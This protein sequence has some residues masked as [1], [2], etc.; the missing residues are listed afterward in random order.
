MLARHSQRPTARHWNGVKHVLQYLRRIE[1][2]GLH[3]TKGGTP[4]IL[5]YADA[6]YK[7]DEASGKSQTGYIFLKNNALISWKSVKQ[8]I[9]ATSTDHLEILAVHEATME[10]VWLWNMHELLIEQCGL[11]LENKLIMIYKDNAACVAQVGAGFIKTNRVKH[12][13][14]Q[15]F[16]FTQELIQS[17]QIEI[18]KIES[19][20]NKVDMLTKAL[21]TYTHRR[22]VQMSRVKLLHELISK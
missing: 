8:T 21:P 18:K 3:Y 14:P 10:A 22:L 1:D 11:T 16:G 5:G 20:H 12:I 7:S 9:T 6:K 2:L 13:S 17:G 4:E 15:I 19:A